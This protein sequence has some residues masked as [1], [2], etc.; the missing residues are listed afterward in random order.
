MHLAAML[1]VGAFIVLQI[2]GA[3][4]AFLIILRLILLRLLV[5]DRHA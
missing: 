1:L 3:L 4:T 5:H 2:I